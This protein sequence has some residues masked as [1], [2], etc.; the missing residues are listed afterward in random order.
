MRSIF[1]RTHV[2]WRVGQSIR[3]DE[4]AENLKAVLISYLKEVYM[5]PGDEIHAVG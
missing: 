3:V 1:L 4:S 2:P 5:L